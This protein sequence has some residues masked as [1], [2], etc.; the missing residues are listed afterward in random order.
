VPRSIVPYRS[1]SARASLALLALNV[2]RLAI[3]RNEHNERKMKRMVESSVKHRSKLGF[4][5]KMNQGEG[6]SSRE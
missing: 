4:G 1:I 6:R 3:Q 5:K 2:R